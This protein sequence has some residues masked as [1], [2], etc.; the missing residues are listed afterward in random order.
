MATLE[1]RLTELLE[2]P[3]QALGFELWGIEFAR[4]GKHSTLRIYI[5]SEQGVSVDNCAEVSYQ[6]GALLDVEDPIS[7]EYYL[8]VSSPGLDRALFKVAHFEKYIGQEAAVTLRM[9]TNNR[10]KFTGVIKAVQG[11]LITLTVDGKDEM[12][13]FTNIQKANIVPHFG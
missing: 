7:E 1:Q 12:L 3:I 9:A 13:A 8:E 10:R 2:A 6:A 11:D 4:A 5:D